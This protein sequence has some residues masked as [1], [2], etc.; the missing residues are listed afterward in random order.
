[1]G[2]SG[3]FFPRKK[4]VVEVRKL[5]KNKQVIIDTNKELELELDANIESKLHVKVSGVRD[6]VGK[7]IYDQYPIKGFSVYACVDSGEMKKMFNDRYYRQEVDI[8]LDKLFGGVSLM[9]EI[10]R[11]HN[12]VL[13]IGTSD[14][15]M[16]FGR[17]RVPVPKIYDTEFRYDQVEVVNMIEGDLR[18]IG[19]IDV[20]V[21]KKWNKKFANQVYHTR[22]SGMYY[23]H[24]IYYP[25]LPPT[26]PDNDHNNDKF[27]AHPRNDIE[28]HPSSPLASRVCTFFP[29]SLL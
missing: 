2:N 24:G 28:T 29:P 6:V 10:Y 25:V 20:E 19:K 11:H 16:I 1:M 18:V 26:L 9:I 14:G 21:E 4:V 8:T 27:H 15:V 12:P 23:R 22:H 5:N 3:S 7:T 13:D 17:C